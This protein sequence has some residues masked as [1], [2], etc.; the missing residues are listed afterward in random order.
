MSSDL[1]MICL[2]PSMTI[3]HGLSSD[4]V[5]MYTTITDVHILEL[6]TPLTL[7]GLAVRITYCDRCNVS[8]RPHGPRRTVRTG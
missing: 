4:S 5:V 3:L 6:A 7:V 8:A 1:Q 2:I